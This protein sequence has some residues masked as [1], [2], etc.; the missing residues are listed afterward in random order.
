MDF[1]YS[2]PVLK[3]WNVAFDGKDIVQYTALTPNEIDP[4]PLSLRIS[5][6]IYRLKDLLYYQFTAKK[7]I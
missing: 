6:S 1:L 5:N 2:K 4:E 7:N 3:K